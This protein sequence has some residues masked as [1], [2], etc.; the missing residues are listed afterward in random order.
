MKALLATPG[1]FHIMALAREL[2]RSGSL[3]RVVSGFPRFALKR[4]RIDPALLITSAFYRTLQFGLGRVGLP[5][6]AELGFLS[7]LSV[8]RAAAAI[9]TGSRELPDVYMALSQTGTLSGKT[10]KSLGVSYV[11]DRGSTHI[12]E[13]ES[14]LAEEH[15][16]QGLEPPRIDPRSV[17][18]ELIEYETSDLI[19]V[20]SGF[21]RRTFVKRG[22]AP[23]KIAVVPYGA[24]LTMFRP[25]SV[26][27]AA[28][29]EVLF[30]GA[31]SL[32][33]G[34]PYLLEAFSKLRHPRKRLTLIGS[35]LRETEALL[36]AF[37]GRDVR[38]LGPIAQARLA[39]HMSESHVLV[40]PSIEEG[41]ALVMAEAM[42][43]GCPVIATKNTGAEDLFADA[44]QGF[45][46]EARDV[47]ALAG[48]MQRLADD[49]DLA[50]RMSIK[51]RAKIESIGG[52]SDYAAT[53]LGHFHRI[54]RTEE[55]G[56]SDAL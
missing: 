41:L 11:C 38:I 24:N 52:W 43:C 47:A 7:T 53:L 45:I 46:V 40:L 25:T 39:E 49:P 33:K 51:A 34:I 8:D 2:Q 56:A 22:V 1:R 54:R 13:Q 48:H 44:D 17:E 6:P 55:T 35:R 42:A 21:V 26:K 16:L 29:F 10:A 32:R 4:E 5:A 14:L 31:L 37:P 15:H 12:L 50:A 9:L 18:R 3:Y 19:T 20:P 23:G 27:P 30:V 28:T 36:R